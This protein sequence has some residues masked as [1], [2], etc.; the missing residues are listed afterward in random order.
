V[1]RGFI[2]SGGVYTTLSHPSAVVP[3]L[4]EGFGTIAAGI[5]G[6]TVV[7]SYTTN[8]QGFNHGYSYSNGVYSPINDPDAGVF[9]TNANGISGNTIVGQFWDSQGIIHGFIETKGVYTT[10]THSSATSETIANGVSG[11]TVVGT[12]YGT[13][14]LAQGFVETGGQFTT[15]NVPGARQTYIFGIDGST[16]SGYYVDA[17]NFSH[18]FV[19]TPLPLPPA[20]VMGLVLVAVAA[21]QPCRRRV[22]RIRG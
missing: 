14:G 15:V 22:G 16:I 7:G 8:S 2:E 10:L 9:G 21:A 20:F 12:F 13:N 18:G 4:S 17:N 6:G 5:S 19:A 3:P 1:S 11:N